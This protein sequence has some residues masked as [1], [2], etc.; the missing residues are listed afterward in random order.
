VIWGVKDAGVD[1]KQLEK[2][3]S[4]LERLCDLLEIHAELKTVEIQR[5]EETED[6][7][8]PKPL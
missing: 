2:L 1:E 4:A 3:S 6:T 7:D 8:I 5:G